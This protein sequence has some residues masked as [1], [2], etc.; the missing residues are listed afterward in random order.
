MASTIPSVSEI[1]PYTLYVYFVQSYLPLIHW[2]FKF[3]LGGRPLL[4]LGSHGNSLLWNWCY[5]HDLWFSRITSKMKL[6]LK[7]LTGLQMCCAFSGARANDSNL[8][9][10]IWL[11]DRCTC[12]RARRLC[13]GYSAA[14]WHDLA[15]QIGGCRE[16][17]MECNSMNASSWKHLIEFKLLPTPTNFLE[18][19]VVLVFQEGS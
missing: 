8:K 11:D 16:T 6:W 1:D 10:E 9:A 12:T 18:G 2:L 7:R 14:G 3:I 13:R 5:R 17:A 15:N 19:R 4:V